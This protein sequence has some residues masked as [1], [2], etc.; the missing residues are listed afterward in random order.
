MSRT[1]IIITTRNRPHLVPRAVQS[2]RASGRNLEIVV[3]DD[4]SSDETA[5]VCQD[6]SDINYVRVEDNRG[7]AGARNIGLN[8]S[9]GEYVSFLDDDDTRLADS[10]DA[11]ID[12]L[13]REPQAGLIYG[14]AIWGTKDG[15]P[16]NKSYPSDCPQ[17]DVFWKLVARNFIPCG[18]AVFRRSCLSHVGLL[19]ESIPGLDD[20]DLWVRIAE[21]YP[22]L[23]TETPVIIWRRSTPVSGQGTSKAA[24]QVSMSVQK[25]R[26]CWM[27]LP[28]AAGATR[29]T[30]RFVWQEFS[31]NMAEH[32]LWESLRALRFG[33][34]RQPVKNLLVLP[35]LEPLTIMRIAERR[36]LRFPRTGFPES[37]NALSI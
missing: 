35:W 32:L 9:R 2:A 13:E 26:D 10:L 1:S 5:A 21:I 18:S 34:F 29:R 12:A 27:N 36:L 37:P 30:K 17:G 15:M 11:Q 8:A 4:A 19:D 3:V 31:E 33:E 7:V 6:L 23:T 14:Q 25:F 24:R 28:R 20:W 22:I 16:S